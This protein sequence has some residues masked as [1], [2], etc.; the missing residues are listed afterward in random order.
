MSLVDWSDVHEQLGYMTLRA[1]VALYGRAITVFEYGQC[2]SPENY[3]TFFD[4]LQSN[5]FSKT[6]SIIVFDAGV[7]NTWFRQIQEEGWLDRV[8][9][10]NWKPNK[11]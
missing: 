5:L 4:K 8:R 3:Q 6:S 1:S 11:P 9:G 2:D 7:R 10:I